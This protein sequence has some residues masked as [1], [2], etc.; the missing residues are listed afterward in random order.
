MLV[1][2]TTRSR[3]SLHLRA[4]TRSFYSFNTPTDTPRIQLDD[5]SKL[6]FRRAENQAAKK[7]TESARLPPLLKKLQPTVTLTPE[8]EDKIRTLRTEDPDT[9]TVQQLARKF[10]VHAT[11]IM[12]IVKCPQ[13]RREM[14]KQEQD[15]Q[16]EA[17]A[18]GQKK[19]KIDRMM[20][21]AMW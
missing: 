18:P 17:L 21:K 14:L 11:T 8:K 20:R 6:I 12:R 9:W 3:L 19:V 13:D 16:W 5:G 15:R 1:R 4:C 10:N 7:T 2:Y